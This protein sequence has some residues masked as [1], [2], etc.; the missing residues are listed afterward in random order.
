MD[1]TFD[2][3]FV[4]LSPYSLDDSVVHV[5]TLCT[6]ESVEPSGVG[7]YDWRQLCIADQALLFHR[8]LGLISYVPHL[9]TLK[10]LCRLC[11]VD[12]LPCVK[13]H[14]CERSGEAHH[15]QG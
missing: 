3:F 2:S 9:L 6:S 15:Y 5:A 8:H 10:W 12:L 14:W 11:H 1:T 4:R 7:A 13:T